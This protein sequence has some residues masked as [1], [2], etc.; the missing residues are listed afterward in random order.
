MKGLQ[1]KTPKKK[2]FIVKKRIN[3]TSQKELR[4]QDLPWELRR[5]PN[6]RFKGQQISRLRPFKG[7][8]YGAADPPRTY[9]A[10]ERA[11]LEEDLRKRGIL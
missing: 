4:M 11:R 8:T 9:S 5:P 1:M 6:N 7:G 10:E 2:K 3:K